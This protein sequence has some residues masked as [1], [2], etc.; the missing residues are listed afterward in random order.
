[1]NGLSS[2]VI[3]HIDVLVVGAGPVGLAATIWFIKNKLKVVLIEQYSEDKNSNKRLFNERHQQV[4]LNPSSLNF[5]KDLDIVVWGEVK[6][7]G[8]SDEDWINIPIYILQNI[9]IKEI[10]NYENAKILFDTKIESVNCTDST[11]SC[12]VLMVSDTSSNSVVY[13]VL[14]RLVIIA[15]GRHDDRGIAKQFFNFSSACKVH[16]STY[17]I[18]GMMVRNVSE[19]SGSVCLKNYT[20]D[21]YLS[22]SHPELGSMYIRLLGNMKER[23][24]ALGL[25]CTEQSDKFLALTPSQI[26]SL[27]VEAYN[28]KRDK[29][30]SE[31]EL[32]GV[33]TANG[34][35]GD[36]NFT[37]CSKI[38][39][40]IVLDYRKETIK[41]LEG[42]STIVSIEGDA[43]R[44]TTFF[45]GSGLNSG[46]NALA[47]LF[48]FCRENQ[49][50]IFNNFGNP[51]SL[52]TI[53]QKLLEKDQDCMH[54]S[55]ELLIKGL[56][57]VAHKDKPSSSS[58]KD[59][60]HLSGHDSVLMTE[61]NPVIYSISPNEGEVPWFIHIIGNNLIG[62]E[63]K[64]PTCVFE[65]GNATS[66]TN[67]VI[68]YD[69]NRVGVKIP[70]NAENKISITLKTSDNKSATSPVQFN[71]IKVSKS[72]EITCV[73]KEDEWLC[74][75]GKNFKVPSYVTIG[76]EKIKAYCN[77]VNSLVFIPPN[78]LSGKISFVVHTDY[79]SSQEFIKDFDTII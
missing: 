36:N 57:Y 64:A 69:N 8:C 11:D 41:L 7:K 60:V 21:S 13:G 5:L 19:E 26:K 23:Y 29:S 76:N 70:K 4:G 67:E 50:L 2:S 16:L 59:G 74:I 45:S 62:S 49:S 63:G 52:L 14:P 65:W 28:L 30:M 48:N 56:H 39:I 46:W 43:A 33:S 66:T 3:N 27:L 40:P 61:R 51:N 32:S 68:V 18:V 79:G 31:P 44:K 72:P 6:K 73:H 9:L 53:D 12:R 38:P 15:D 20:S 35:G 24:I 47:K 54:I 10:R 17:G 77:S 37:E 25:G 1:M 58:S 42:S 75:E 71:A 55:L 34:T 78:K 22:E